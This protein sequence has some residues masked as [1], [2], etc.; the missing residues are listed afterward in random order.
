MFASGGIVGEARQQ[1]IVQFLVPR[2]W[3]VPRGTIGLAAT[4][5]WGKAQALDVEI[6]RV[7][8]Q[9]KGWPSLLSISGPPGCRWMGSGSQK[10]I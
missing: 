10:I 6:L 1:L 9:L 7:G 5:H 2:L 4:L 8:R 3:F